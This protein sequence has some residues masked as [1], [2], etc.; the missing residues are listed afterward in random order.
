MSASDPTWLAGYLYYT[1]AQ[2][3]FLTKAVAPF[4]QAVLAHGW[5]R[6][7]FFIRYGERGPHIRLRF[8]GPADLLEHRVK[9]QLM[10]FFQQYYAHYPSQRDEPAWVQ[11]L[12]AETQWFPNNS[13]QFLAYEPEIERYGGAAGMRIA[14]QQFHAS[15]WTVLALLQDSE[16]WS[17]DRALGAAIQLHLTFAAGLGMDW[18]EALRFYT[19]VAQHWSH[20][21]A[22]F[23][24]EQSPQAR[25]QH[26]DKILRTFAQHFHQ[27]QATLVPYHATLWRALTD[28]V[29]FEHDW[30]NQWRHDMQ[31]VGCALRRA[32]AQQQLLVPP[33]RP[34][35]TTSAR[36][37]T[38][39][40]L[41]PL[42]ESYVH[43]TNN[44]LGILN[45]DEAY[46]AYL[47][48]QSLQA[49]SAA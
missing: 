9:P 1:G 26:R 25:A 17:Y 8:R 41:W 28:D 44:R 19:S 48:Q 16:H 18:H 32:Q 30:L 43:M 31:Q 37:T 14:E 46:L 22:L 36:P 35:D 23:A 12:P 38:L 49:L 40:Q 3:T 39:Q 33:E 45:R 13:V 27:Q 10:T 24:P 21:P 42:F 34:F 7:F 20:H 5:A 11:D 2:E 15:S 6:Q 47:M 29:A 4:V